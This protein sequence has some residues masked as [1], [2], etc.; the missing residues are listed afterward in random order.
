MALPEAPDDPDRPDVANALRVLLAQ[1]HDVEDTLA[2]RLGLG[3]SDVIALQH[4]VDHTELGP[5]DLGHLLRIR[6]A[7]ATALVD[8]LQSAGHVRRVRHPTDGRRVV[9]ALTDSARTEAGAAL[10]PMLGAL[11]AVIAEFTP[12]E[13]RSIARFLNRATE[14]LAAFAAEPP[15]PPAR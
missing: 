8:R 3:V 2:R 1:T 5:V 14:A 13:Q 10:A 15:P 7:S 11:G 9:L 4:L 12:D 6:S